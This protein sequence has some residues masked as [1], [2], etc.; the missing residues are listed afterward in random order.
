MIVGS[1]SEHSESFDVVQDVSHC[2]LHAFAAYKQTNVN[3]SMVRF[4]VSVR[5]LQYG[6]LILSTSNAGR[7]VLKRKFKYDL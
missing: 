7:T 4:M 5:K 6:F 2:F 1:E 3:L